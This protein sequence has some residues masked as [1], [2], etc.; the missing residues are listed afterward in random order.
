V[1]GAEGVVVACCC[2]MEYE[3]I[4]FHDWSPVQ[5]RILLRKAIACDVWPLREGLVGTPGVNEAGDNA[6][7]V[8]QRLL[9]VVQ[10]AINLIGQDYVEHLFGGKEDDAERIT[11]IAVPTSRSTSG[12]IFMIP[13]HAGALKSPDTAPT[14]F[15]S[16][17]TAGFSEATWMPYETETFN[18][19]WKSSSFRMWLRFISE[20]TQLYETHVS[21]QAGKE[22]RIAFPSR[23]SFDKNSAGLLLAGLFMSGECL[24]AWL[25]H[26]LNPRYQTKTLRRHM[27]DK[28]FQVIVQACQA[29]HDRSVRQMLIKR[30]NQFRDLAYP[31]EQQHLTP[32]LLQKAPAAAAAAA[33]AA[34]CIRQDTGVDNAVVDMIIDQPACM[35]R[36]EASNFSSECSNNNRKSSSQT[37]RKRRRC[38]D[39]TTSKNDVD[40]TDV[41]L[42]LPSSSSPTT[43]SIIQA[44][45]ES[46]LLELEETSQSKTCVASASCDDVA[47]DAFCHNLAV[48]IQRA[49]T[50]SKL[51]PHGVERLR[52]VILT[53]FPVPGR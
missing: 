37:I 49:F 21:Q 19:I 38:A 42:S 31:R 39:Q 16:S 46:P 30:V 29:L 35:S 6:I 47:H 18:D 40:N 2:T 51:R 36:P 32:V 22:L 9:G 34:S 26:T 11:L 23:E 4:D 41:I 15:I 53:V 48:L 12:D 28:K 52:E 33:A 13:N 45:L 50:M 44:L 10:F 8:Q 1:E 14:I 20:S 17:S 27:S 25:F 3:E 24:F 7:S 5:I 43:Q